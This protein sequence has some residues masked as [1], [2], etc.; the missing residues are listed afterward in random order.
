MNT[1][2]KEIAVRFVSVSFSYTEI[3][4]L[5]NASFHIHRSEFAVMVG[6]NG[7]GKTTVIK[8][9]FGLANPDAGNIELFGSSATAGKK[10]NKSSL[11]YVPQHFPSDHFFPISVHD[12]V[13]MGLLRPLKRYSRL[14][15]KID[16]N[17]AIEE[18]LE[19]TGIQD[20]ASKQYRSL[21]GGQK[22]RALVARALAAKP[23]L[24]VLDEPT[25]NM[26]SESEMRLYETLAFL[27]GKT[28]IL[29]VTHDT[30]FVTSLAD[31][32]LCLGDGSRAIVQ[33]RIEQNASSLHTGGHHCGE[34]VRVMHEVNISAEDCC[35]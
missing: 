12:I 11:A 4:V 28:T 1:A 18:A 6:P 23:D 20:L 26:D 35:K 32:V 15:A 14:N 17:T 7:S 2:E 31:R 3:Q 13:K 22:R 10:F 9:L 27:K 21:S 29:I 25:A 19:R 5:K 24:L 30:E 16:I 33:H 8:L 34:E